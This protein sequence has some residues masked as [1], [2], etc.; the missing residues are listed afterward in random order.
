MVVEVLVMKRSEVEIFND[1]IIHMC[2][3][4]STKRP[5]EPLEHIHKR[6]HTVWERMEREYGNESSDLTPR[7]NR[8]LI[9]YKKEF[10]S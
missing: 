3:L 4:D 7:T 1:V 9:P 6:V 10:W 8:F 5:N 2:L